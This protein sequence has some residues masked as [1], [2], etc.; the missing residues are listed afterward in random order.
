VND[1]DVA[2]TMVTYRRDGRTILDH[3]S[4]TARSGEVTAIVGPSGSGKSSLLAILAGIEQPDSGT[5]TN[6]FPPEQISLI[7]QA[8]GL[9]S[10]LT[11]AENVEIALQSD[12]RLTP[13]EIRSRAAVALGLVGLTAVA[14]HLTES[15]SGGQQQRVAIARALV[16]HPQLLIADEF[17]AELDTA[18]RDHMNALIQKVAHDGGTVIIA[19]HDIDVSR[20][21]DQV[22]TL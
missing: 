16:T 4:L 11:A 15:L 22:I 9:V 21:A 2:A 14:D 6:S 19:T 3:V 7:L 10:L 13:A 1:R 18:S 12:N 17:T 8:Y 20:S 5:V